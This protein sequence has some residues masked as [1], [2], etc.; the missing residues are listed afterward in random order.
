M[1]LFLTLLLCASISIAL[2]ENTFRQQN[3]TQIKSSTDTSATKLKKASKKKPK[4]RSQIKK[5]NSEEMKPTPEQQEGM[6]IRRGLL[7][8][9]SRKDTAGVN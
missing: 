4:Q 7:L 5:A 6:E 1:K 2:S 8:K 3:V 9:E